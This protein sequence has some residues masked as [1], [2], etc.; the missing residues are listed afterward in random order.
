MREKLHDRRFEESGSSFF[1]R[2]I[3]HVREQRIRSRRAFVYRRLMAAFPRE[4]SAAVRSAEKAVNVSILIY[5]RL[6]A[7]SFS[8]LATPSKKDRWRRE[9]KRGVVKQ[10]RPED[11]ESVAFRVVKAFI[12]S[13]MQR[14]KQKKVK[15][16][17]RKKEDKEA[18]KRRET[19]ELRVP[20]P[21][22][23]R[24]VTQ[25]TFPRLAATLS[26]MATVFY[27]AALI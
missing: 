15:G 23:P 18:K 19:E 17:A 25:L 2:Q 9:R 6:K 3:I 14:W 5:I 27:E 20:K 26:L 7:F 1:V 16:A 8:S 10:G 24:F 21:I 4:K 12:I 22:S 13:V 11:R